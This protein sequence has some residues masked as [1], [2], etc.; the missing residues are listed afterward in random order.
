[1]PEITESVISKEEDDNR[2][3]FNLNQSREVSG[4]KLF[5]NSKNDSSFKLPNIR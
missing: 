4:K 2:D 3:E 1:M 5:E